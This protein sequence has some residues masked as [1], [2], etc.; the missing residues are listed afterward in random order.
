MAVALTR[1][2][3]VRALLSGD[4]SFPSWHWGQVSI[5]LTNLVSRPEGL[6][7]ITSAQGYG[8]SY[9]GGAGLLN[10]AFQLACSHNDRLLEAIALCEMACWAH[11]VELSIRH[12]ESAREALL[13]D[14]AVVEDR[15]VNVA[16][17]SALPATLE[18][19]D[20]PDVVLVP[21]SIFGID[22]RHCMELDEIRNLERIASRRLETEAVLGP[23]RQLLELIEWNLN[24]FTLRRDSEFFR[25][26][27]QCV[28]Q[29]LQHKDWHGA[30]QI[31]YMTLYSAET[32]FGIG[33]WWYAIFGIRYA[34]SLLKQGKVEMAAEV[35][36]PLANLL[37]DW[38]PE[39]ES[40]VFRQEWRQLQETIEAL[41]EARYIDD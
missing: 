11:S 3:F 30:E 19:A 29:M 22:T 13:S 1:V 39:P 25:N 17:T 15:L 20:R 5:D 36:E 40:S 10:Q 9:Q 33:H 24:Q 27:L 14:I 23:R 7:L 8:S 28:N 26:R 38:V 35:L 31:A 18:R 6:A 34:A 32:S 37:L 2:E 4:S 16:A 21:G 12:L 41:E